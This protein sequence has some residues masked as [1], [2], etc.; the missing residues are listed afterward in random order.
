MEVTIKYKTYCNDDA[1]YN[2]GL[3]PLALG[4]SGQGSI[5]QPMAIAVSAGC[6]LH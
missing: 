4:F 6:L 2:A 5:N 1:Y 3:I